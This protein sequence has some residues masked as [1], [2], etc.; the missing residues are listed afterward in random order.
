MTGKELLRLNRLAGD[1]VKESCLK[2]EFSERKENEGVSEF[3]KGSSATFK[4]CGDR[5]RALLVKMNFSMKKG[6]V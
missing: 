2:A 5:L 3:L 4:D 6:E 1:F